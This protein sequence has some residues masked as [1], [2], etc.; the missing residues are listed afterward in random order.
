MDR[1][2]IVIAAAALAAVSCKNEGGSA[3]TRSRVN[4]V[5]AEPAQAADPA[6]MCDVHYPA[7]RAPHYAAPALLGPVGIDTSSGWRWINVWATWCKPCVEELPRLAA[8]RERLTAASVAFH[9]QLISAD[10]AGTDLDAFLAEHGRGLGTRQ[11]GDPDALQ[12]W[13]A[14]LGLKGATLPVQIFV[15]PA[16]KVRCLRASAVEESDFDAIAALLGGA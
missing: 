5:K 6:A 9:L 2:S 1:L 12:D 3:S 16:G 15:D 14:G 11:L 10:E 8:W 7:A 4:A 13:L